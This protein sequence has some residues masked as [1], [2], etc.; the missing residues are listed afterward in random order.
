ME[1]RLFRNWAKKIEEKERRSETRLLLSERIKKEEATLAA[2]AGKDCKEHA[3]AIKALAEAQKAL[4]EIDSTDDKNRS[5]SRRGALGI[6]LGAVKVAVGGI[7]V[8]ITYGLEADKGWFLSNK[9]SGRMAN[10]IFRESTR[11]NTRF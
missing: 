7:L 10:D 3:E 9:E 2:L 4:A 6:L 8:W 11:D 1:I 5:E